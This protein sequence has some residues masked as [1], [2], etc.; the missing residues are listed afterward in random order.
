MLTN[1]VLNV[2]DQSENQFYPKWHGDQC[3]SMK[4]NQLGKMMCAVLKR[5]DWLSVLRNIKK[6]NFILAII[7]QSTIIGCT[8]IVM[9]LNVKPV[10]LVN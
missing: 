8:P 3:L 7:F 2:R 6:K 1:K 5:G 4:K 9:S 10:R